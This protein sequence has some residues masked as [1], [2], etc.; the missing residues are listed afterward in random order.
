MDYNGYRQYKE[1]SV[2]TM[3]Q[4]EM[5]VALY[6]EVIKCLTKAKLCCYNEEYDE[7][8]SAVKRARDIIS[9]F[10]QTLDRR[11][12]I[13]VSLMKL[14]EFINYKFACV[15]ASRNIEIIEEVTPFVVE[16]RDTWK[17]ADKLSKTQK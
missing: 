14:Y 7:F 3:T 15:I 2:S 8:E 16:L 9:Y 11:Y 1:Q 10:E 13:S 12:P 6:D 17:E 4:G 5:L